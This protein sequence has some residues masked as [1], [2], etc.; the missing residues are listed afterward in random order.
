MTAYTRAPEVAQIAWTLI[1]Q[2]HPHLEHVRIDYVW[3]DEAAISGGRVTLGKARRVSG[4]GAFLGRSDRDSDLYEEF[5][6]VE[7]AADAW[8][9]LNTDQRFALVDHELCH[10]GIDPIKGTVAM[11]RHDVEEFVDIVDRHGLWKRDVAELVLAGKGHQVLPY[12][13]PSAVAP[14]DQERV[15]DQE[16][17]D[18]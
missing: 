15:P 6:V 8:A 3:R 16:P 17:T 12:A 4:L 5:F 9:G 14:D 1:Q 7:I 13:D 10:L 11:R 2:H 18:A